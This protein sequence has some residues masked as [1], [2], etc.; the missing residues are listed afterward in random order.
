MN[1][2]LI[3]TELRLFGRDPG[4]M[5][6][7]F[8]LSPVILIILGSIP[9]FRTPDPALGGLRVIDL[10][11]PIIAAMAL[12][13]IAISALPT[14]LVTYRERGILRR[15]ATTP[16]RPAALLVAQLVA[17][18]LMALASIVTV[19]LLGRTAF[20]VALPRNPL[21][22]A[23]S[24]LLALLALF[25]I[26][27]LLAAR[28]RGTRLV[29][30]LGSMVFFPLMFFAGLWLPREVMPVPLRDISNFTPLGA[31]VQ[32]LQDSSA[33]SWPGLLQVGVLVG[34]ALVSGL[35]AVRLFRWH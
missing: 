18:A 31:A 21:A 25:G 14:Q 3:R 11:V 9:G 22:F 15:L 26:G 1:R 12:A 5:V 7:G 32:A 13:M 34:Y 33:G 20:A 6:F 8:A 28:V 35:A 30:G 27:L 4:A 19:M 10:Y 24:L 17:Y 23:A 2:S 16:V 29:A